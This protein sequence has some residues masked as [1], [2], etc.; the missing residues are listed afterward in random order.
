MKL[1][2]WRRNNLLKMEGSQSGAFLISIVG[3]CFLSLLFLIF[4]YT[5]VFVEPSLLIKEK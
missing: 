2:Q 3:V 4:V 5:C 1:P